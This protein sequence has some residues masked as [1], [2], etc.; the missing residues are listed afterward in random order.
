[1]KIE[2]L[3]HV[4]SKRFSMVIRVKW[5][6]PIRRPQSLPCP[7][8]WHTAKN[9][10]FLLICYVLFLF[11]KEFLNKIGKNHVYHFSYQL[12][13]IIELHAKLFCFLRF[14]SFPLSFMKKMVE[15]PG[16]A[17]H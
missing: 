8:S 14:F 16:M 12:V 10:F 6:Q 17:I 13:H 9:G 7:E 1:M 15:M 4:G 11:V 5:P 2:P 3:D